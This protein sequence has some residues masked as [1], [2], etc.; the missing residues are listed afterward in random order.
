MS[1]RYT[2]IHNSFNTPIIIDTLLNRSEVIFNHNDDEIKA[3]VIVD[4]LNQHAER[5][6]QLEAIARELYEG[7][8]VDLLPLQAKAYA[9][10]VGK[11]EVG[12]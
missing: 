4:L 1:E 2:V 11:R 10:F 6:Q 3:A 5:V 8:D 7:G 12:E 9:Y